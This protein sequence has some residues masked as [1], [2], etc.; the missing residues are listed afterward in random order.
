M[1]PEGLLSSQWKSTT[2]PS[3]F[4]STLHTSLLLIKIHFNIMLSSA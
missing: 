2:R 1:E 3:S 4:D